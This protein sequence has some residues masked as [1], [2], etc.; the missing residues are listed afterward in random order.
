MAPGTEGG[1]TRLMPSGEP[2]TVFAASERYR[3]Q[4]VPLIVIAG[5]NYGCGSSRDWAAKGTQL[6]GIR[7]VVAESFE[8]I[9]RSN[10]IGMGV[11]PL[12]FN[13]GE[14]RESL[15]LTGHEIFTIEGVS[16]LTPRKP[17]TVRA[18]SEKAQ[19]KQFTAKARV[20]TP[21]EVSYYKHGGI[22]QY[23]LRQML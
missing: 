5:A 15:G 4:G 19:E 13:P 23:V 17:I 20:D 1:F 21:E 18:K 7:A 2:T 3:Q 9:H 6:L 11:L 22:L 14:T 8:R 16:A 12:E 10:L